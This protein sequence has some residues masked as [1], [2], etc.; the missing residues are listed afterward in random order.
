MR[1]RCSSVGL[2]FGLASG[3]FAMLASR[4]PTARPAPAAARVQ[5]CE[6]TIRGGVVRDQDF[7]HAF[8]DGLVFRL[9]AMRS[10]PPNPE[11]WR[12]EV[13][14]RAFPEHEYSYYVSPPL[15][16]WNPRYIDTSYGYTA[17]RAV[18]HDVREFRFLTNEEDFALARRAVE[19]VLWPG[20]YSDAEYDAAV[21]GLGELAKGRGTLRILDAELSPATN[22]RPLGAIERLQFEVELCLSEKPEAVPG[23]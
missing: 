22:E 21:R 14:P 12:I 19:V 5:E 6:P 8:A 9:A 4:V 18:E 17:A 11:G 15:R 23:G 10:S 7:E 2:I 1:R 20:N 13:R 3:A 16:F